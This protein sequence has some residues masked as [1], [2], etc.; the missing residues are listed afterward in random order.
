M[1]SLDFRAGKWV[2]CTC[3]CGRR[4]DIKVHRIVE[5]PPGRE[6]HVRL[7]FLDDARNFRH[8]TRRSESAR[9]RNRTRVTPCTTD[10]TT[11]RR[12]TPPPTG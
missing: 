10:T 1:L 11:A 5:R 9:R 7:A 12:T 2:F 4:L 3:E 8:P 6:P